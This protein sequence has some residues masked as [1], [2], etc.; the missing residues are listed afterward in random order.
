MGD[1]LKTNLK[2]QTG[3]EFIDLSGTQ[4]LIPLAYR[5]LENVIYRID[6]KNEWLPISVTFTAKLELAFVL[7]FE[8]AFSYSFHFKGNRKS[9]GSS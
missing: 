9:I 1:G 3:D 6:G 2:R 5:C 4:A 8:N 7:T